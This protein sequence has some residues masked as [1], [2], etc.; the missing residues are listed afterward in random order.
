MWRNGPFNVQ[1]WAERGFLSALGV[2]RQT[3]PAADEQA[4]A[5]LARVR[6]AV[7]ALRGSGPDDDDEAWYDSALD[8]ACNAIG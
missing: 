6:A 3:A 5:Y 2:L 4:S 8:E 7:R 1:R